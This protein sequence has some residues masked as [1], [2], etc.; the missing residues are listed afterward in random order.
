MVTIM[1]TNMNEAPA[2]EAETAER[3]VDGEHG[4]GYGHRGRSRPLDA[5]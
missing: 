4:G 1:V 3:S 2:F 5:D